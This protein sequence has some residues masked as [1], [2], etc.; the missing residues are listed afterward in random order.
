[1]V[2]ANLGYVHEFKDGHVS[3]HIIK[4]RCGQNMASTRKVLQHGE[5]GGDK[6]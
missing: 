3:Q 4:G 2:H 1:L 5:H 6:G